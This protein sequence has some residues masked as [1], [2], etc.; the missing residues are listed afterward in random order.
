MRPCN[1]CGAPVENNL[2]VCSACAERNESTGYEPKVSVR[3][4]GP[5]NQPKDPEPDYDP[6]LGQIATLF[7]VILLLIGAGIAYGLG[8]STVLILFSGFC[9]LVFSF[10][11]LRL[12]I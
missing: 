7:H 8:A 3:P 11:F 12:M 9:G 6:S 2:I 4:F 1:Q 5:D 10:V